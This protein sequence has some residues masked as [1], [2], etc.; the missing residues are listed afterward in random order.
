MV[1]FAVAVQADGADVAKVVWQNNKLIPAAAAHS[2]HEIIL[3]K[4]Y[5]DYS[6]VLTSTPEYRHYSLLYRRTYYPCFSIT[7]VDEDSLI[8]KF[9]TSTETLSISSSDDDLLFVP[10][11]KQFF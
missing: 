1:R 4:F 9:R 5:S 8:V 7:L 2:P 10:N 11:G 3:V 6:D